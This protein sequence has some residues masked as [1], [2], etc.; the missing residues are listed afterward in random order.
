MLES[1]RS[2]HSGSIGLRVEAFESLGVKISGIA[3]GNQAV[4]E[5]ADF[6]GCLDVLADALFFFFFSSGLLSEA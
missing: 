3:V 6:S 4:A 1:A 5:H 2:A